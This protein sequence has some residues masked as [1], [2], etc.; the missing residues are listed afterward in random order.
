MTVY[1]DQFLA[2]ANPENIR[3]IILQQG[4]D[5][6]ALKQSVIELQSLSSIADEGGDLGQFS[7]TM[8]AMGLLQSVMLDQAVIGDIVIVSK[9]SGALAADV[10]DTATTVDFGRAMDTGDWVKVQG[11]DINGDTQA[12]WMLVGALV[13]DTTY[14]VTRD[15]D[16]SGANGWAMKTPF[17]IIGQEGD[18][19]IELVAGTN[20]S[21]QL[22]TQ[23]A[24]WDDYTVQ[25]SMST[26]DGAIV[27]GSGSVRLD[28]SGITLLNAIINGSIVKNDGGSWDITHTAQVGSNQNKMKFGLAS[29]AL[30]NDSEAVWEL[31]DLDAVSPNLLTTNAGFEVGNTSGWTATVTSGSF[32][33][34]ASLVDSY[35]GTYHARSIGNKSNTPVGKLETA[36]ANRAT[37]AAETQYKVSFAAKHYL[38]SGSA[39]QVYVD[40]YNA[41]GTLLSSVL[42]YSPTSASVVPWTLIDTVIT[43]P[44]SASKAG[45]RAQI[46]L[47]HYQAY[48]GIDAAYIGAVPD[49]VGMKLTPEGVVIGLDG[50]PISGVKIGTY[51]PT[52]SLG[53]NMDSVGSVIANVVKFGNFYLVWGSITNIN[54][55]AANAITTFNIT[56]P[57]SLIFDNNGQLN[58]GF[59]RRGAAGATPFTGGSVSGSAGGSTA[60]FVWTPTHADARTYSFWF[61]FWA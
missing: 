6:E 24:T 45:I 56:L 44:A 30:N 26:V 13:E 25:A 37:V 60:S 38:R 42:V 32:S 59:A 49:K 43:S 9:G 17:S 31:E 12:E 27:A 4:R 33:V 8:E 51:T 20:A 36:T 21:I 3:N 18:S 34:F 48:I 40:F 39:M 7:G 58:G 28:S 52:V 23:G 61:F 41:G 57:V 53:T 15:V 11:K 22:I 16:G 46:S 14:N 54:P 55:T 10:E 35:D 50:T 5:I 47:A 29:N 1:S 19:R 2:D